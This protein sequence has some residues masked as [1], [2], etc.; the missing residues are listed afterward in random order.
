MFK[1]SNKIRCYEISLDVFCL[2]FLLKQARLSINQENTLFKVIKN[3]ANPLTMNFALL[4]MPLIGG[5]AASGRSRSL[6]CGAFRTCA[7]AADA[8]SERRLSC[9]HLQR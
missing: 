7:G 5:H 1:N 6:E 2:K 9:S 4:L 3:L 8:R